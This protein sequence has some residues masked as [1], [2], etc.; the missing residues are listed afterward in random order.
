MQTIAVEM[1]MEYIFAVM[2][3]LPIIFQKK[4]HTYVQRYKIFTDNR[5]P[6]LKVS[7]ISSSFG[8]SRALVILTTL[9][10]LES[11]EPL[12][13]STSLKRLDS[14]IIK[15]AKHARRK[16]GPERRHS[17]RREWLERSAADGMRM[18]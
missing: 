4:A 9:E 10:S 3:L 18:R 1:A 16:C 17:S 12:E 7:C 2:N 5:N 15:T 6:N 13:S 11:F 14:F 8:F